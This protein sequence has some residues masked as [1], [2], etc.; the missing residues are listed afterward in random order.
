MIALGAF[1]A[2]NCRTEPRQVELLLNIFA[3]LHFLGQRSLVAI[4][5]AG[6][7]GNCLTDGFFNVYGQSSLYVALP[8]CKKLDAGVRLSFEDG[9]TLFNT[10]DIPAVGAL[11]SRVREDCWGNLTFFYRVQTCA[12]RAASSAALRGSRQ[13]RGSQ[14]DCR[15]Y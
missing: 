12:R 5:L 14:T 3:P 15:S 4:N 13:A 11:A 10:P 6:K 9:V 2:S 8:I 1:A 7:L